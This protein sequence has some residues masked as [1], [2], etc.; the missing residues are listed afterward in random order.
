VAQQ[1]TNAEL[2]EGTF[3]TERVEVHGGEFQL[4]RTTQSKDVWQF[5]LWN[6]TEQKYIRKSTRQKDLERAK[7]VATQFWKEIIAEQKADTVNAKRKRIRKS[8]GN[9]ILEQHEL[10]EGDV[11][12]FRVAQSG[13][14]WQVYIWVREEQKAIKKSLRTKQEDLARDRAK[15]IYLEYLGKVQSN[16]PIFDRKAKELTD[17]Y[18]QHQQNRY[19][20]GS[21]TKQFVQTLKARMNHYLRF[22]GENTALAKIKE[23]KFED[24]RLFRKQAAPN[25][26][27][28]TLYNERGT[29]KALYNFAKEKNFIHNGYEPRFGEWEK[30]KKS[31]EKLNRDALTPQEWTT[32]YTYMQKW[33]QKHYVKNEK[34]AEQR[35]FIRE[36]TL[37]L[38]NS[39]VRF[40]EAR[41]LQWRDIELY[42][43]TVVENGEKLKKKRAKINLPASKTKTGTERT[44]ISR[45]GNPFIRLKKLSKHTKADDY[46][47]V[48]NETGVQIQKAVYYRQWNAMLNDTGLDK[49]DKDIVYYCLRHTYATFALYKGADIFSLSKIMGCGIDFIQ[50]HYGHVEIDK[51]RDQF[52]KDLRDTEGGRMLLEIESINSSV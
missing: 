26:K 43:Q 40:G 42:D 39:G 14:V 41:R 23:D 33:H 9:K 10:F 50:N 32:I 35:K 4:F 31:G 19:K 6:G 18:I 12:I 29:I 52:T 27:L 47:F 49:A 44:A 1:I 48:D 11:K 28:M 22:V 46:I 17:A 15:K 16:Q 45:L 24:Y 8:K 36:F 5:R 3:I 30:I 25:V 38:C 37:I 20:Q 21:I 7:R 13:K 34:E 2:A 51:V